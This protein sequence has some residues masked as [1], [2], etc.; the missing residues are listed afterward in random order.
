MSAP[1][2]IG[3][4]SIGLFL[5]EEVR[6][7]DWWPEQTVSEWAS[8]QILHSSSRQSLPPDTP[9][10]GTHAVIQAMAPFAMDPFQG[11]CE[12]RVMSSATSAV[13]M[14]IQATEEAIAKSGIARRELDLLLGFTMIPDYIN[15]PNVCILH[16]RLGLSKKCFTMCADSVCNS[17]QMQLALAEQMILGGKAHYGLL[18]QSSA[19]WRVNDPQ[20]PLSVHFGDGATAVIIGPVSKGRGILANAHRT[21]GSL[22]KAV[23]CTVKDKH[24]WEEGRLFTTTP[25]R[26]ATRKMVL[27]SAECAEE[28]SKE[29][30]EMAH[31]TPE[32]ID[33][34]ACHQATV[35]FREMAQNYLGLQ[36]AKTLD[37][38]TCAGTLSAANIPLVLY[39]A[40][41]EGLLKDGDNVLMYQAGSGMTYSAT[42]LRWGR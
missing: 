29:A 36:R 35:W 37:T 24:W 40:D 32:D 6:K 4:Y 21:D 42:V 8:R 3:I 5:P 39:E 26:E 10:R 38:Y 19:I 27:M 11:A 9:Y 16:D 31:L 30:L 25:D 15:A 18:V 14:E 33:F 34:F 7:N 20:L 23:Y 12:R 17:F 22:H 1:E 41:K 28:V 2:G 13:D